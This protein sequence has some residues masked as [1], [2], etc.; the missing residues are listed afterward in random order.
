LIHS[1]PNQAS[2]SLATGLRGK[3]RGG[4]EQTSSIAGEIELGVIFK[5]AF[6]KS[7]LEGGEGGRRKEGGGERNLLAKVKI[8]GYGFDDV[9]GRYLKLKVTVR[10]GKGKGRRKKSIYT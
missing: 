4:G 1:S 2:W 5:S 8:L 7:H 9:W 6:E 10:G 3:G